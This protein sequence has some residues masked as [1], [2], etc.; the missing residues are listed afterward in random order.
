MSSRT[1]IAYE[2][3]HNKMVK[4]LLLGDS[5][6]ASAER[7]RKKW[8]FSLS[9]LMLKKDFPFSPRQILFKF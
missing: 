9:Q 7:E 1:I 6:Q 5:A 4:H 8:L 2:Q 3:S